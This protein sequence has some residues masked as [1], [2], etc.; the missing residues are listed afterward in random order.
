MSVPAVPHPLF[1]TYTRFGELNF[2]SLRE[3]NPSVIEYLEQFSEQVQA[4]EALPY[5]AQ[6]PQ[7]MSGEAMFNY[8]RTHVE[9]LRSWILIIGGHSATQF[10]R[11]NVSARRST[12][13]LLHPVPTNYSKA[14]LRKSSKRKSKY[15][16]PNTD[17]NDTRIL[18]TL[19]WDFE[20]E[21]AE[22]MA[23]TDPRHE[24]TLFIVATIFA[25]YFR[26]S[27]PC[28]AR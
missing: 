21:T 27:A 26:V 1:E 14:L 28:W 25:M 3:E 12:T 23:A 16:Q 7:V 13:A 2:S 11:R 20:L 10:P 4:L 6:F 24:R 17:N 5:R 9:R 18:T 22:N 15:K 19:Q 8:C